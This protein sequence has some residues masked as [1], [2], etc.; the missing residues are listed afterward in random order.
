[1]ELAD[2]PEDGLSP[3][4][5]GTEH[6]LT[7]LNVDTRFIPARAGNSSP[8][9]NSCVLEAVY[10]RSRGE[11]DPISCRTRSNSGLSPLARGT[12][13]YQQAKRYPRR[14]IPARA[15][16]R[17]SSSFAWSNNSV[18]P[19][20]RGEQ[21]PLGWA[22]EAETGLSPL[23]RGTGRQQN[24]W[25][26]LDRF[27]PARAGTDDKIVVISD[28]GRF[29]PARA[30][31][32]TGRRSEMG[33]RAVYPRSRGERHI[34]ARTLPDLRGLSPLARGTVLRAWRPPPTSRFIPARAGNGLTV[35]LCTDWHF[36]ALH[37][38]PT[39]LQQPILLKNGCPVDFEGVFSRRL[40]AV[41]IYRIVHPV[42]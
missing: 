30:G 34:A 32:G 38:L 9:G 39:F 14:F 17:T 18:Y 7:S 35:T 1:M 8:G 25:R 11:Q 29:I 10:P 19:R 15:G 22:S 28:T 20:S 13:Y 21:N 27:I 5:R 26:L 33:A 6:K 2:A 36:F 31:N 37:I 3:L 12:D 41:N 24:Y 42:R 16:N 4:A 23:A 40:W